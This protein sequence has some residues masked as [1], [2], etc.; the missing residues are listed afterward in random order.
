MDVFIQRMEE[1]QRMNESEIS[2]RVCAL[3]MNFGIG[4]ET[5]VVREISE[6]L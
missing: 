2:M 1:E 5:S 4:A 6:M 3:I